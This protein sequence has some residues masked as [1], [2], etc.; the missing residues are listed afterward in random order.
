ML[1]AQR[2]Y[3]TFGTNVAVYGLLACILVGCSSTNKHLNQQQESKTQQSIVLSAKPLEIDTQP[4]FENIVVPD[5]PAKKNSELMAASI[6]DIT[7]RNTTKPDTPTNSTSVNSIKVLNK[8]VCR[9]NVAVS[10]TVTD[11]NGHTGVYKAKVQAQG[12][13]ILVGEEQRYFK[14]R[15]TGWFTRNEN[16]YQWQPYLKQ[17][18]IAKDISI[19]IGAEFWD[20]AKNWYLCGT[21]NI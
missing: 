18:P 4:S 6:S 17:P 19:I 9:D 3:R 7:E 1:I 14:I 15:T 11:Q 8:E 2:I 16:L 20:K 21:I 13:V 12:I 5:I 10:Y